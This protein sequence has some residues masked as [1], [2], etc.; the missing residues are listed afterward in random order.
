MFWLSNLD[1]FLNDANYLYLQKR[2]LISLYIGYFHT[3]EFYFNLWLRSFTA[4]TGICIGIDYRSR[5]EEFHLLAHRTFSCI[6]I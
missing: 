1:L 3:F 5:K 4:I 6:F 2:D